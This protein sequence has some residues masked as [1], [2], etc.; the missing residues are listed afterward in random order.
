MSSASDFNPTGGL[1]H[2]FPVFFCLIFLMVIGIFVAAIVR[3]GTTWFRNNQ[4]P[5]LTVAA[6]VVTKRT[7]MRPY[8]EHHL[9]ESFVTFQVES[10]DRLELRV[11]GS[12]YGL[13]AEGDVGQL[14]FQGSRY[15]GFARQKGGDTHEAAGI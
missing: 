4:S 3:G 8:S 11:K 1:F 13:L 5:V 6:S 12:E 7:Q 9:A 14:T 15:L 2:L 10:G